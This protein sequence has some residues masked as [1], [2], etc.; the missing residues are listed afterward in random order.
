M[1]I[2]SLVMFVL[3]LVGGF[4]LLSYPT[5]KMI[6]W[7]HGAR[8]AV[9]TEG[10]LQARFRFRIIAAAA[11]IVI[12]ATSAILREVLAATIWWNPLVLPAT[13]GAVIGVIVCYRL[14]F[15]DLRPVGWER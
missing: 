14:G 13:I 7:F 8:F 10:D 6:G 2:L 9:L 3:G 5:A 11:L 12:G 1:I 4:L 15:H